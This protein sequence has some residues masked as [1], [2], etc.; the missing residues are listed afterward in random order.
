[1]QMDTDKGWNVKSYY[2]F[3][4]LVLGIGAIVLG[5]VSPSLY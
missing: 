3:W 4:L 1:M 2:R 5:F